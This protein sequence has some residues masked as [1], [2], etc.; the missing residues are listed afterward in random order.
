MTRGALEAFGC[1]AA[2]VVG[3]FVGKQAFS[4]DFKCRVLILRSTVLVP[5]L[6]IKGRFLRQKFSF[7]PKVK[8]V[9]RA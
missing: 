1:E 4:G 8:K 9:V 2:I 5:L 7:A 3:V 6:Q